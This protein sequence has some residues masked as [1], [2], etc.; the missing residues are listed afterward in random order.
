MY[1]ACKQMFAALPL[2]A[3][4]GGAALVV[5]GGLFRRPAQRSALRGAGGQAL[6]KKRKRYAPIRLANAA[7][8]LGSLEVCY[9]QACK[10]AEEPAILP[11]CLHGQPLPY[12]EY[13]ESAGT[14]RGCSAHACLERT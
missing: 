3:V 1:K 11:A 12:G 5:H 9:H 8:C 10:C 7:P 13:S 14:R 4:I 2:A 6:P